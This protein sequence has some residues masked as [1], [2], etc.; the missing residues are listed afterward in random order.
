M[1]KYGVN[2]DDFLEWYFEDAEDYIIFAKEIVSRL[3]KGEKRTTITVKE[4]FD[5]CADIPTYL[6]IPLRDNGRNVED[7]DGIDPSECKLIY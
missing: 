2:A 1:I 3:K 5:Q 4:L 7:L 6:C